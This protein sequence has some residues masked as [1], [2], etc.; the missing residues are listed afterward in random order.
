VNHLFAFDLQ[1]AAGQGLPPRVAGADEAGR[2]ALAGP[3]VAAAVCF[4]YEAWTAAD[5]EALSGLNDSKQ[6]TRER[7]ESLLDEIV[8]RAARLAVVCRAPASIDGRGLHVCNKEALGE[9]LQALV[10][11]PAL[12]LVDGFA[13]D[14]CVVAHRAV[15]GG[16]GRSAAVA[17][18]SILAKVTRD[19]LMCALHA[20]Y[21]EWGFEEHVGYATPGHHEA[22]LQYGLCAL[23]RRSFDSVAY[24]QLELGWMSRAPG[25]STAAAE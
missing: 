24:Q 21:P 3:L 4:D 14:A 13:L 25:G 1:E 20:A 5:F 19:R 16:D 9:A 18:A 23:H 15:I 6:V 2:G 12:A 7:R 17:A 22:I 11:P 8:P 10:P